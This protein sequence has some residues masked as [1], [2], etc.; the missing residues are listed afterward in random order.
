LIEH[1][2]SLPIIA[3]RVRQSM[4]ELPSGSVRS[5][6]SNITVRTLGA[7]D[8]VED[9]RSIV[10]KS[11]PQGRVLTLGE[12]ADVQA[13][14]ED[15]DFLLRL[16]G[17][18][19]A[20]L[21]VFKVGNEDAVKIAE[22]VKAYVAGR[23]GEVIHPTW[24][25]RLVQN[26][27]A[28]NPRSTTTT[29]VTPRLEAYELGTFNTA[30]PPGELTTT[31]DLSRFIVGRLELLSR[32]AL[33][34][35]IL[36]FLTLV[37]LLNVRVAFW[38]SLGVVVSLFG[39]LAFMRAVGI[40]LNLLT[41]FGL[42]IVIG[43]LVDDGIVISENIIRKH[44]RGRSPKDAAIEGTNQ[45]AWPVIGTV[46]T[47]I[48]AFLPLAM[49]EGQLGD[50]LGILPAVVVCALS[51][52][53]M[54]VL[55]I[56]PNHMAHSL[57]DLDERHTPGHATWLQRIEFKFDDTRERFFNQ[58]LIPFYASILHFCLRRRYLTLCA[59]VSITVFSGALVA[60]GRLPFVFFESADSEILTVS[61]RMPTGTPIEATEKTVTKIETAALHQPEVTSVLTIIG[62]SGSFDGRESTV[63][64]H[65]AQV[66]VEL[67]PVES[68]KRPSREV[69]QSMYRELDTLTGVKSLRIEETSGGPEGPPITLTVTSD[70]PS[71]ITPAVEHI[72]HL[73]GEFDGVMQIADDSE[74]GQRELRI[75]LL[76]AATPLGLTTESLAQ[77]IRG[78]VYGLEAHTFAGDE[79][80]VD[81]R[82]T[83]P[84]QTR[85]S[86]AAIE[87][88]NILAP[89]GQS[90]PLSEVAQVSESVG[91]SAFSRLDRRR[92]VTIT[93]DYDTARNPDT[94]VED[95]I[96]TLTPKLKAIERANPGILIVERGRQK[97][98]ADSFRTLPI[99]LAAAIG[100]NYVILAWLFGSYLQP[101]VILTAVPFA[102]VGVVAG[103]LLLGFNMTFVSLIGFIALTGVV[104]N[105]S[106]VFMK[107]YN[108]EHAGGVPIYNALVNS[109]RARLRPILLTTITTVLGLLPL[110]AEQSFQ[111]RFLIPMAITITFGLM[112][113]TVLILL[114][115]PC[116]IL[117]FAD[118][119]HFARRVWNIGLDPWQLPQH[120]HDDN[121]RSAD[122]DGHALSDIDT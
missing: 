60:G 86:L 45:V 52:S 104:V 7:D 77:Q 109:G 87:Q 79:E 32:N 117:I 53:L 94:S 83:L 24:R 75:E 66:V 68:R 108:H 8:H 57:A 102:V 111:A 42:I 70:S 35:G 95:I 59:A 44:E 23:R 99:G 10:I 61:L 40:T 73:L 28:L 90:V 58:M 62:S 46:L 81:V 114:V 51:V 115:L 25:E 47:T 97:D 107:F 105:D 116:L 85:R 22:M 39:T 122:L 76:D 82:V 80:D 31:T 18:P 2:L 49:I 91:Y 14:F 21:T 74:V 36:V 96:A 37:L 34:G 6:T 55:F 19:A 113:S 33:W 5:S 67:Q 38:V 98:V 93:A 12:I 48:V 89:N 17:K 84:R 41:M 29:P 50:M 103:Y 11:T 110:L 1:E 112:S 92:A 13:T 43:I 3:E 15:V 27:R 78:A 9:V 118:C 71:Q 16:N 4:L 72:K 100:M 56:L 88:L 54:E 30:P 69:M 119:V 26:L 121:F 101:L 20:S 63:Q 64:P 120:H 65:V 106:I